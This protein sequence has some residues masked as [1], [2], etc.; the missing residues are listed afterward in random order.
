MK[1]FSLFYPMNYKKSPMNMSKEAINDLSLDYIVEILTENDFEQNSIKQLM[2]QIEC[3]EIL[4]KYRCDVFEDFLNLP[5]LRLRLTELL[6]MLS[7]LREIEKF[8]KDSDSSSLW[9]LINRMREINRYIECIKTLKATLEKL[10]LNSEGLCTLRNLVNNIYSDGSFEPLQQ[11][12][13]DVFKQARQLH[14]I[15]IG[16]NLD[17][18]LRPVRAGILSLNSR[19]FTDSGVLKRFMSIS[20]KKEKGIQ[21]GN[22]YAHLRSFHSASS[23]EFKLTYDDGPTGQDRLSDS[24]KQVVTEIM[25][26]IVRNIKDVL[27]KH[28]NVNGYTFISL[29]PEIIFYIRWAELI[30]KIRAKNLPLCKAEILPAEKREINAND[31]YNLKLAI[32]AVKGEDIDIVTNDLIFND[33]MGRIFILTGPNRGGKTTVTQALGLAVLMAQCGIYVPCSSLQLSPCDNIYTHFPADEN[34]T[35]DLGRLGEES[36]R[37]AEIFNNA[38]SKSLLLLNESLATT[39]VTEGVY[40][41]TD[42]IKA[43][44]YLGVRCIFNTHMHE[45]AT[46]VN[47]INNSVE[48]KSKIESMVTGIEKGKRSFKISVNPPQG[49][50]YAKDIAEHYGV[51][52]GKIKSIID[53]RDNK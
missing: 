49:L 26:R 28:V 20:S 3:S 39:N 31:I 22:D 40:I 53:N 7:E 45:L 37:L 2:T 15:T 29:M 1:E 4:I 14:S 43:M 41:A 32:K 19:E 46:N 10:D 47:K 5:E 51:T 21:P 33:D 12:I 13:E 8:K 44:R 36:S 23:K 30:D 48:G 34:E 9:Q 11:A 6:K 24:M 25:D 42:V 17:D 52:F 50:S 18:M 35:V 16:V 38:T 27:R